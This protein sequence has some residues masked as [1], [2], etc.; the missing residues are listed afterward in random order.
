MVAKYGRGKYLMVPVEEEDKEF[1]PSDLDEVDYVKKPVA[2]AVTKGICVC[3]WN[4]MG[5]MA[6]GCLLIAVCRPFF[7]FSQCLSGFVRERE[8]EDS[9]SDD[10]DSKDGDKPSAASFC[11]Y[12]T[13]LTLFSYV[14]VCMSTVFGGYTKNTYTQIVLSGAEFS[15]A[16]EVAF[17]F[18][19][20]SGGTVAYLHGACFVY[21][22]FGTLC[23][24][25]VCV[26]AFVI[27]ATRIDLFAN[28]ASAW[29]I[30]S[31][32][33]GTFFATVVSGVTSFEFMQIF[34][35]TADTLLYV[36]AWNRTLSAAE[37]EFSTSKYCPGALR[38]MMPDFE[39]EPGGGLECAEYTPADFIQR[40]GWDFAWRRWNTRKPPESR[41]TSRVSTSRKSGPSS[42]SGGSISSAP[43]SRKSHGGGHGGG[44]LE[45]ID[46]LEAPLMMGGGESAR[47]LSFR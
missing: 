20:E 25:L 12:D 3:F 42:I 35:H 17:E 31:L 33:W 26:T 41:S 16:A 47:E 34:S 23:I 7:L 24:T 28:P 8:G 11:S 29:Y 19:E 44:H 22:V 38:D 15:E 13:W 37:P 46:E 9:D 39:L 2:C 10:D 45:P 36:F 43:S 1:G 5:S 27:S 6:Y 18:I 30:P 32:Y 14:G 4:H 21:E 40:A